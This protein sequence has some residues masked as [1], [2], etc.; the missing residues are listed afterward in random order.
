M[1]VSMRKPI[2]S[3]WLMALLVF[4][5]ASIT[6]AGIPKII[7]YQGKLT[8]NVGGAVSDGNYSMTFTIYDAISG[9]NSLWTSGSQTVAVAQGLFTYRLGSN[10]TI[11][12]T[13]FSTGTNRYLGIQ[14]GADAELS[15][16]SQILASAYSF[17]ALKADTA[18][19]A[20]GDDRWETVDSVIFT[21][22]YFGLSRGGVDNVLLGDSIQ[23]H[24][25]FGV[26]CTT[27]S[28]YSSIIGGL[29][30]RANKRGAGVFGGYIN[31]AMW[32]YS[33]I[34]GG[35]ENTTFGSVSFIGG[36]Q[37]N[38]VGGNRSAIIGGAAD[39]VQGISSIIL[40]GEFNYSSGNNSSII[41]GS[42]NYNAGQ[43]GHI[44]GGAYDTLGSGA[45]GTMVFGTNVYLNSG[46]RVGFFESENPGYLGIN[47]DDNDGG[48][49]YPIHVG[50]TT[51]D[52]NGAHL[53]TGGVWTNGSSREFKTDFI[54]IDRQSLFSSIS[55][56]QIDSWNFRESDEKHIGPIAEEFVE[57]FD[58]GT[59]REDGSRENQYL[60]S[61][62][63][64]GVALLGVQELI[65]ENNELR[66]AVEE[67]RREIDLLKQGR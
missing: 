59:T 3:L 20:R 10:V 30:N 31:R 52:G 27:D 57:E 58:V 62:D 6:T 7:N 9:G 22:G 24:I 67:L 34:T 60:S 19:Y 15:P 4:A 38:Y 43:Y 50:T 18:E 54:P 46:S 45:S 36:G 56:L 29:G 35:Y 40:A 16:R 5:L 21:N 14:V 23:S 66:K 64:A 8:D 28:R 41:G 65:T 37:Q 32:D 39:T 55:R 47:R 51:S 2:S 33:A 61:G 26:K 49:S 53:T 42:H 63:V 12:D 44:I 1:E 11:P 17:Q 48:I 25:N 13:V